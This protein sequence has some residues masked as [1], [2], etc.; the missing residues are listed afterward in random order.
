MISK[1]KL[2]D[3]QKRGQRKVFIVKSRYLSRIWRSTFKSSIDPSSKRNINVTNTYEIVTLSVYNGL[4][5]SIVMIFFIPPPLKL[6]G[7]LNCICLSI[8]FYWPCETLLSLQ[9]R[10]HHTH[11]L[12]CFAPSGFVLR[13][14]P[15][16][17]TLCARCERHLVTTSCYTIQYNTIQYNTI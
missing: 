4:L 11:I 10:G 6:G 3:W 16:S 12:G 15:W 1:I 13:F 5:D 9:S 2:S 14:A 7:S 17:F 8:V